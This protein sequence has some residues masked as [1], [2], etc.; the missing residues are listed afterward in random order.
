MP[1]RAGHSLVSDFGIGELGPISTGGY[2]PNAVMDR[3]AQL[4]ASNQ[5]YFPDGRPRFP[6]NVMQPYHQQG[7]REN[8]A[9]G[10]ASFVPVVG[11]AVNWG[12]MGPKERALSVGLD[13]AD[14]LTL[15]GGKPL[16]AS[17]RLL[18][19]GLQNPFGFGPA[20]NFV[21]GGLPPMDKFGNL[22][23][24]KNY[25]TMQPEA[26][27]SVYQTAKMPWPSKT[28]VF[29]TAPDVDITRPLPSS[30]NASSFIP[31]TPN[32][33]INPLYG[34]ESVMRSRASDMYRLLGNVIPGAKGSDWEALVN[35][36]TMYG[37]PGVFR[38]GKFFPGV[39]P[40]PFN[41]FQRLPGSELLDPQVGDLRRLTGLGSGT[42]L[43]KASMH[44]TAVAKE[45]FA[46]Y[47]PQGARILTPFEEVLE[48]ASR[49]NIPST[50]PYTTTGR[51]G[52]D[53]TWDTPGIFGGVPPAN[54]GNLS[55]GG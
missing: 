42:G 38:G 20:L 43:P 5:L 44:D 31:G 13:A 24:S 53:F 16:T 32:Y 4:E 30:S 39:E 2:N 37:K 26:G 19:K 23:K 8:L 36:A 22:I 18:S 33:T 21:R 9:R 17:A 48:Q 7:R 49:A 6:L 27:I 35:E 15:G 28:Q 12:Q 47:N 46:K 34:Q 11:T 1:H 3:L 14:I 41:Q 50:L 54:R 29:R 45:L 40:I 10:A 51:S 55:P 52:L 25:R